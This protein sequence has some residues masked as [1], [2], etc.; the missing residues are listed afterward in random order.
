M[1]M[2]ADNFWHPTER[3]KNGCYGIFRKV[4]KGK[5]T[6]IEYHYTGFIYSDIET[7]QRVANDLNSKEN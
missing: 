5:E 2:A 7:A 4:A 6:S 1:E 3:T